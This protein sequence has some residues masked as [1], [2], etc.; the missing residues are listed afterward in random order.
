MLAGCLI[1]IGIVRRPGHQQARGVD[2][3]LQWA[4]EEADLHRMVWEAM[5]DEAD[6]LARDRTLL[7][8]VTRLVR[9]ADAGRR[10]RV[11]PAPAEFS[12]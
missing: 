1:R 8:S 4:P 5:H 12:G 3:A 11:T 6:Y 9:V 10:S 2:L 7:V